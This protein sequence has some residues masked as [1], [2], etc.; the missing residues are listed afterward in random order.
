MVFHDTDNH[1]PIKDA[2]DSL[3]EFFQ[4]EVFRLVHVLSERQSSLRQRV[5]YGF[6]ND[7]PITTVVALQFL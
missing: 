1:E 5:Q 7:L 6:S 4:L 2:L 3:S